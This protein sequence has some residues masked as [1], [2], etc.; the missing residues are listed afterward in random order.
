MFQDN[1][2]AAQEEEK[3]LCGSLYSLGFAEER[4]S[5]RTSRVLKEFNSL[6]VIYGMPSVLFIEDAYRL[7]RTH[8]LCDRSQASQD[9][10]NCY[11]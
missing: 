5:D 3:S 11:C 7:V 6:A 4:D 2:T 1:D 8:P 10:N 9:R